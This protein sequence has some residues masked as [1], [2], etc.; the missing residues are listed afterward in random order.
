M[1]RLL[2]EEWEWPQ[3][4]SMVVFSLVRETKEKEERKR[5]DN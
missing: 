2:A 4:W 5:G 3:A 1:G